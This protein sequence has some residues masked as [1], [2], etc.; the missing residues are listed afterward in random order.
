M[1]VPGRLRLGAAVSAT[2]TENEP[3]LELPC[4]SAAVHV[5]VVEPSENVAPEAGE[6]VVAT[7]PSTRSV[8]EAAKLTAAPAAD[9]ASAV[10]VP[11]TARAGGVVSETTTANEAV[12]T[13]PF[14]S[15]ALQSIGVEPTTNALPEAGLH[16]VEATASSGS[17]AAN[18]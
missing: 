10:S 2:T 8:A 18:A 15:T 11:G 9:F 12:P 14:E 16:V 13:L 7:A 5:T 4:A 1:I 17:V 3:L 6:H